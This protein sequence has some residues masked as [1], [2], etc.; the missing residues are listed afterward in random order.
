[1]HK[2][3]ID[4]G[5]D[6]VFHGHEHLYHHQERDG[7]HYFISGGGGADLYAE[8]ANGGFHHYLHVSVTED[9]FVVEVK[10]ITP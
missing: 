9:G 6:A 4:C 2:L 10:R 5:V 8:P 7:G 1:M 3:F